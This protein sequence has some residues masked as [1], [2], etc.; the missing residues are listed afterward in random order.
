M[1]PQIDVVGGFRQSHFYDERIRFIA[2]TAIRCSRGDKPPKIADVEA[3]GFVVRPYANKRELHHFP[4]AHVR[5]HASNM[6][7]QAA[8]ILSGALIGYLPDHFAARW[9]RKAA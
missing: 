3:D 2:A 7:A 8:F 6:E 1:T 5:A 9:V 4:S